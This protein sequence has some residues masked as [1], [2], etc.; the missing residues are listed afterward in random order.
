MRLADPVALYRTEMALARGM[1]PLDGVLLTLTVPRA[2]VEG[3]ESGWL[4]G[5]PAIRAAGIPVHVVAGA[6]HVMMLDDPAGFARAITDA[7]AE[8]TA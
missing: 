1:S 3:E 4:S 2:I 5:D 7:L 6:G 8:L